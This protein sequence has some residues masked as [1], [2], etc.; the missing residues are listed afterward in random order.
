MSEA[1]DKIESY[2]PRNDKIIFS[3]IQKISSGTFS[4]ETD[5]GLQVRNQVEDVK[6][7]RWAL[8]EAVGPEVPDHVKVGSYILIKQLMWTEG[9]KVGDV[10]KWATGFDKILA[11][12]EVEPVGLY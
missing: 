8:V 9:F 11:T 3:F 12:S 5:W 4:N 2:K 10:K 6:T 1:Y 7:P